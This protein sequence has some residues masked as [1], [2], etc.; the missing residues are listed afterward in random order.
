MRQQPP[1]SPYAIPRLDGPS[2]LILK[3]ALRTGL[4]GEDAIRLLTPRGESDDSSD[5]DRKD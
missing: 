3:A 5:R 2:R 4:R 1:P